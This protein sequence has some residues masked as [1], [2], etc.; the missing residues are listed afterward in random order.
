MAV[1]MVRA[2][3]YLYQYYGGYAVTH[4]LPEPEQKLPIGSFCALRQR[5]DGFVSVDA[6]WDGGEFLTPPLVFSGKR[7]VLNLNASAMGLCQV[8]LL[9]PEGQP[10]E[11]LTADDCDELRGN[12]TA[13]V[14]SWAGKSDVAALAGK[15]IRLHFAMRAAELYA[16]QF[17]D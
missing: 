2:G 14:V 8:G 11:G 10:V 15:P 5:L 1:G 4:G 12:S 13:Q 3:N 7:L 16:F 6:G 9:D 17:E